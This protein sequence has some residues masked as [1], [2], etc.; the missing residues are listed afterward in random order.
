MNNILDI[1]ITSIISIIAAP[2]LI[3]FGGLISWFLKTRSD[4]IKAMEERAIE[5]RF[6]TYKVILNPFIMLFAASKTN[7]TKIHE[8]A[9]SEI[10]S[11]E[12]RRAG[13]DLMTF[14]SDQMVTSYNDM[15]Q[16]FYKGTNEEDP[17]ATMRKFANFIL[18]VRKDLYNKNTK[19]KHWDML[20]FMINDF[21]TAI[22][23]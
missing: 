1:N 6:E 9:L 23:E 13:F 8:K 20:K 21:D 10:T 11:V 22:N 17:N 14:G 4:D 16:G 15:M 7:N 2:V 12:Y 5:K 19:L 18:S 3:F